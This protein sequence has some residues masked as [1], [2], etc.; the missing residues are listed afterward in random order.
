MN[1]R[2]DYHGGQEHCQAELQLS[3]NIRMVN[4]RGMILIFA[5]F[6]LLLGGQSV[7]DGNWGRQR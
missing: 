3:F 4:R 2:E 1:L 6:L 5:F 7:L